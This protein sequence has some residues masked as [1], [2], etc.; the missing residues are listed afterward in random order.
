MNKILYKIF[1]FIFKNIKPFDWSY[2][3]QYPSFIIYGIRFN[4][5]RE[6][7]VVGI[8]NSLAFFYGKNYKVIQWLD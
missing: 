5:F 8:H 7:G 1:R 6:D 2:S 3:K 4:K